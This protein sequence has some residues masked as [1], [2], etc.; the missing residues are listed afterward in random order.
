MTFRVTY[1]YDGNVSSKEIVADSWEHARLTFN[2]LYTC[3]R[4]ISIVQV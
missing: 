1:L 4:I 3:E 2:R